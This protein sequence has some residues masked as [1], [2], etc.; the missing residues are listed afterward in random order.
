MEISDINFLKFLTGE[1]Q[2]IL[3]TLVNLRQDVDVFSH[4]D[5]LYREPFGLI[6]VPIGEEPIPSL[7]LFGVHS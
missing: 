2:N 1:E 5:S 4:L 3:S 6:D 7:Y